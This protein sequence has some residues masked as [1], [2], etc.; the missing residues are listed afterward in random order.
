MNQ[1]TPVRGTVPSIRKTSPLE[2]KSV[3]LKSN[4]LS[5]HSIAVGVCG[6]IGSV[7]VVKII[8]ELRRHGADITAFFTPSV[9][10]FITPLPVEWASGHQ[11]VRSLDSEV[12]HFDDFSLVVIVPA[13]LNTISKAASAIADNAV[14][15]LIASQIG[16]KTPLLFVPTMNVVLSRHPKYLENKKQLEAW[17]AL[18]LGSDVEEGRL[19]V[20]S[21]EVLANEVLK[22]LSC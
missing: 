5:G 13:T 3:E 7:E 11:V 16:K 4:R 17:G 14:T 15:M 2:D 22:V 9:A 1:T 21:P 6:G 18:F 8:R 12:E 19:K 10:Q 20:P